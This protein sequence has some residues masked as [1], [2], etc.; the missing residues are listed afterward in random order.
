MI[1]SEDIC[2]ATTGMV[3][4]DTGSAAQGGWD[5][6]TGRW[7]DMS[8]SDDDD[9]PPAAERTS[10]GGSA[11][12]QGPSAAD[13]ADRW[14]SSADGSANGPS[15]DQ[16]PSS[17]GGSAAPAADS[18][19]WRPSSAGGSGGWYGSVPEPPEPPTNPWTGRGGRP[20]ALRCRQCHRGWA[21]TQCKFESCLGCCPVRDEEGIVCL[22]HSF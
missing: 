12:G 17:A 2:Q 5:V 19:D 14:P 9:K 8:S 18:A 6:R 4:G 21:P 10:A 1:R 22:R 7:A 11:N 16:R 20:M 13:S 15:A 3:H